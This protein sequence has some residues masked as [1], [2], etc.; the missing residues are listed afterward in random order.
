MTSEQIPEQTQSPSQAAFTELGGL[1][2]GGLPLNDVLDR[3]AEL[4]KTVVRLPI[5][6]SVTLIEG[7]HATTPS[8]TAQLALDL[9]HTQYD[10]GYG[11]CLAAAEAAHRVLIPDV[12][13]DNRWP[14]FATAALDR[15]VA[16][17]LSVP[18]PVQRQV[19]GALNLYAQQVDVFDD[20]T[21]A[22]GVR[23]G[24]YAAAAIANTKLFTSAAELAQQMAQAMASRADI[25]QAKGILMAQRRCSADE[26]FDLLVNLSQTSHRKLR[27]VAG[28]VIAEVVEKS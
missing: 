25:E 8:Y 27:D 20:R 16:S 5:E 12:K 26:A 6:A 13:T 28:V 1:A 24:A 15:G 21:V 17:M 2:L 23:F 11:P 10:L 19:I 22:L 18:L 3:T 7:E 4:A 14:D 9:D